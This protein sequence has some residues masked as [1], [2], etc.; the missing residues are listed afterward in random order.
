MQT[1]I[2]PFLISNFFISGIIGILFAARWWLADRLTSRMRY[3]VWFLLLGLLAVPFLP[4]PS[5]WPAQL[6]S[7]LESLLASP[8]SPLEAALTETT[9]SYPPVPAGWISDFSATLQS[10][11]PSGIAVSLSFLWLTGAAVRAASLRQSFLR[12]RCLQK[13]A[14][15]LQNP[16]IR[17]LY[18][19]CLKEMKVSKP[20]PIYSTAYL[21]SPVLAGFWKPSIYLPIHLL[22]GFR[23]KDIRYMLL[24]ELQHYRHKDALANSFMNLAGILYWFNPLVRIALREMKNDREIACDAS[25]LNMLK[26]CDYKDYGNTLLNFAEQISCAPFPFA[27]GMGGTM[28]Q[29]KK[30]ILNIASYRP[31]SLQ[32]NI[33]SFLACLILAALLSGFVPLLS[34]QAAEQNRYPF[35]AKGSNVVSLDLDSVFEEYNGCFVLYDAAK[36]TWQ[37]YRQEY[38]QTRIP[39]VSTIKIYSALSALESGLISPGQ[40]LLA[41]KGQRFAYPQWNADQTLN[42]AMQHSVTWY[43][44]ELDCMSGRAAIQAFLRK[45]DYGNRKVGGDLS[46]YWADASLLISPIEQ[47]ELLRKFYNNQFGFSQANIDAVKNAIRLSST[48]QS[49]LYGK[50][51]TGEANG[52]NILGWFVG[53]IEKEGNLYFFATHIQQEENASGSVAADLTLSILSGLGI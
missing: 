17:R 34:I 3:H 1:F 14:L 6:L 29:M 51:G 12:L 27:A 20:L 33:R 30:R 13:S 44:Q 4:L 16:A 48:G 35:Q 37:I 28:A 19:S 22:S 40:S 53:F 46:A 47:V 43:F 26:E 45:I 15:P 49:V 5:A 42:S 9:V 38:A 24:H 2:F 11:A 18:H 7:R 50:T 23:A 10:K 32:K 8:A 25:V 39:P 52:R 41:W 36:D 21:K 31:A